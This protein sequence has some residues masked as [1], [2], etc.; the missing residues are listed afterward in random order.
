MEGLSIVTVQPGSSLRRFDD[1]SRESPRESHSPQGFAISIGLSVNSNLT[2][3]LRYIVSREQ[4]RS[5]AGCIII[6]G[7]PRLERSTL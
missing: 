4:L 6:G 5:G 7:K 2:A 1:C 3:N